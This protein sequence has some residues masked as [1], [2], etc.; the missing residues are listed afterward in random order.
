MQSTTFRHFAFLVFLWSLVVTTVVVADALRA[1]RFASPLQSLTIWDSEVKDETQSR[2]LK[3]LDKYASGLKA[4]TEARRTLAGGEEPF[5]ETTVKSGE[6]KG[7][8][9]QAATKERNKFRAEEEYVEHSYDEAIQKYAASQGPSKKRPNN[10]ANQ[11][12]FVGVVNAATSEA[13]ITWYARKKPSNSKWSVRLIHANRNAII[14]D[15]FNR[16]KVDI[17]AQYEN[18]GQ[19]DPETNAPVIVSKYSV[20]NRSWRY[21]NP[22]AGNAF[23]SSVVIV[24]LS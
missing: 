13:P 12:Q 24:D 20:A 1:I 8:A 23:F 6:G 22:T 14:K 9:K 10:F 11:Y 17:F 7:W 4:E 15:M 18:T 2:R 16:G 21:A 5:L 19:I 3:F